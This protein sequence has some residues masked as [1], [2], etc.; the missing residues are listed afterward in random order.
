MNKSIG[1]VDRPQCHAI[2]AYHVYAN[3]ANV[4]AREFMLFI[5]VLF[6]LLS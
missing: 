5:N 4:N 2:N 1:P 6:S 3:Y